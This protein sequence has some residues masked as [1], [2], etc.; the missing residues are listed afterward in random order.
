MTVPY[1]SVR[2]TASL[3]P[4]VL[5]WCFGCTTTTPPPD[6]TEQQQSPTSIS[7]WRRTP[8]PSPRTDADH[9]PRAKA[10]EPTVTEVQLRNGLRVVIVEQHRR[11]IVSLRFVF[12]Q[13]AA[14][15]PPGTIGATYFAVSLLS[16]Y[17]E[18]DRD[19]RPLAEADSFARQVFYLG[20]QVVQNVRA[21]QAIFGIDGYAKDTPTYLRMLS[22]ALVQPRCGPRAFRVRRNAM[23]HFLEEVELSD[24]LVFQLFVNR[25]AFG[26]GHPYARAPFGTIDSLKAL[27]LPQVKRRQ[28]AL[29]NPSATTLLVVGDV[30]PTETLSAIRSTFGRWPSRRAKDIRPVRPPK[31][32]ARIQPLLIPRTPAA[33]MLI[34]ATRTLVDIQG[35]QGVL[36]VLAQI[37]GHGLDSRLGLELRMKTGLSYSFSA[38]IL[39]RRHGRALVA[40]TRTRAAQTAQALT[41]FDRALQGLAAAPPSNEELERAKRQLIVQDKNLNASTTVTVDNWLRALSLG[42]TRPKNEDSITTVTPTE[43]YA[44]AQQVL[45]KAKLQFVLGGAPKV[46]HQA[47]AAAGLGPLRTVRL[48]L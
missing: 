12:G 26:T 31:R 43:V 41:A 16:D 15:D 46:A 11:P 9:R 10:A 17:Y 39:E 4:L 3:T 40:C 36:R 48:D 5:F 6:G 34:C 1:V 33:S 7:R 37:L 38:E 42:R 29:L 20:G 24:Q 14:Q 44:L 13:G 23:I 30:D 27:R 2:A 25:A 22:Q 35:Q 32:R 47:A 19:G 8:P 45:T 21:D 18:V 28:S